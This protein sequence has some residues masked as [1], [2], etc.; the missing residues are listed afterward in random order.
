MTEILNHHPLKQYTGQASSNNGLILV[1]VLLIGFAAFQQIQLGKLRG[2]LKETNYTLAE[3]SRQLQAMQLK[4]DQM[5][6]ALKQFESRI[7]Y[8]DNKV[9]HVI[10]ENTQKEQQLQAVTPIHRDF[11]R[12]EAEEEGGFFSG[13]ARWLRND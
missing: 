8:M 10:E 3:T 11:D 4:N 7:G 6:N 13:I 9:E 12:S 2:D 1:V 5:F